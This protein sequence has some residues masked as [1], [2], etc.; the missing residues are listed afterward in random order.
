MGVGFLIFGAFIGFVWWQAVENGAS[1]VIAAVVAIG[2]LCLGAME[3][4]WSAIRDAETAAAQTKRAFEI[5]LTEI[6]QE[7][8]EI[9]HTLQRLG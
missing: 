9:R 6:E 8:R 2:A 7:V 4:I 5:K 3:G 1:P